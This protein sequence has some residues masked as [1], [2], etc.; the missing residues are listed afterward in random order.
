M[1]RHGFIFAACR[2][3]PTNRRIFYT[4]KSQFGR[5]WECSALSNQNIF[6]KLMREKLIEVKLPFAQKFIPNLE[7]KFLNLTVN[8]IIQKLKT[9]GLNMCDQT[10]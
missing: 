8:K 9:E 6:V 10:N 1:V 3:L 2:W 5:Q 7:E 4:D